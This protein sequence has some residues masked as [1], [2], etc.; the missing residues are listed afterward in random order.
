[1]DKR[2]EINAAL[3][4]SLKQKN[5]VATSTIRLILAAIKDKDIVAKGE[6]NSEGISDSNILSLLQSMIKQRHES[7]QTYEEAG[8]PELA[9]RERLEIDVISH[10]LPQQMNESETSDIIDQL[11]QELNI[12]ELKDMGKIMRE[13]KARYAGQLDMSEASNIVKQKLAH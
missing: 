7:A 1:M 9:E 11:I 2:T 6:G 3:K 12:S 5:Q 8:R 13:I 10:F 4:D